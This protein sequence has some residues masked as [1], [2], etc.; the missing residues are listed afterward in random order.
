MLMKAVKSSISRI[1]LRRGHVITKFEKMG[2]KYTHL[3]N[4]N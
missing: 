1:R 2:N 4:K 3:F